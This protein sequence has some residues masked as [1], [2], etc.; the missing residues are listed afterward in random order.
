MPYVLLH[1]ANKILG[2]IPNYHGHVEDVTLHLYRGAFKLKNVTITKES[3]KIPVPFFDAPVIDFSVQWSEVFHGALVAEVSVF[4]PKMNFVAGPTEETRQLTI[5]KV[6]IQKVRRLFPLKFNRFQI[7]DGTI[8]F[9]NF[10]SDPKIDVFVRDVNATATNL[11]NS[12]KLSKTLIAQLD[13]TGHPL[14]DAYL[15]LHLEFDPFSHLPTFYLTEELSEVDVPKLNDLLK[16][17]GK[18]DAESGK[19]GLYTEINAT[20][21]EFHGYAK[22]IFNHLKIL[23]WG[24][25]TDN[26]LQLFWEAILEGVKDVLTNYDENKQQFA[27]KIPLSGSLEDPEADLWS[28]IGNLLRNAFIRAIMPGVDYTIKTQK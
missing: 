15:S 19:F 22:P 5:S 3:G 10:H 25:H 27:T 21:G 1:Y 26:P 4:H 17:Y 2:E 11:T 6:W 9:R 7:Y 8:H 12:L 13:A 28:T 14:G 18:F 23:K 20:K 16:V 24:E